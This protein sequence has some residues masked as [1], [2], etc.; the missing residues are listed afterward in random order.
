MVVFPGTCNVL[1]RSYLGE[2]NTGEV[3]DVSIL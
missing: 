3:P 1:E 2:A